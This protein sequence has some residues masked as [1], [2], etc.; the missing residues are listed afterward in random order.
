MDLKLCDGKFRL[1]IRKTS[2]QKG[3]LSIGEQAAQESGES[4]CLE[5]F[6]IYVN[7]APGDMV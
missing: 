5:I 1:D 3:L 2:S 4:P 7:L 6:K